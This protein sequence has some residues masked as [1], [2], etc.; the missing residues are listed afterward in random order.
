MRTPSVVIG[1]KRDQ[2]HLV[3]DVP[4]ARDAA[5]Q[6]QSLMQIIHV[7]RDSLQPHDAILRHDAHVIGKDVRIIVQ[8]LF[9][10]RREHGV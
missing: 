6:R 1:T 5:R 9:H 8:G 2:L 3:H 10:L 4:P 7:E